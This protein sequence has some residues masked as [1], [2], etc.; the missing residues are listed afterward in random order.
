MN[1]KAAVVCAGYL[2][3]CLAGF[4]AS[5]MYNARMSRMPYDT[6][7]G[8][9]AF[10]EAM[11]GFSVFLLVALIPTL[12]ALWFLRRNTTLWLSIAIASLGFAI[13]GLIAVLMPMGYHE[14]P[15]NLFM[16]FISLLAL[17]QL[18]GVPFWTVAFVLFAFLA[19]TRQTRRL[20]FAAIGIELVIGVRAA[21]H[22]FGG[23]H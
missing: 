13:A 20:I 16:V 23:P 15:T 5:Y 8:M 12:L 22:W 4:V 17:A 1:T 9:Y 7:G 10:G 14:S 18:L 6:S 11:S 2:F 21:I 19:P 3:A